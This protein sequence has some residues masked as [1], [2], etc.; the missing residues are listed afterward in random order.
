[1]QEAFTI[2]QRVRWSDV[3]QAGIAYYGHLL[4]FVDVVEAELFR[5]VGLPYPEILSRFDILLPR[6]RINVEFHAPA[7][8]DDIVQVSAYV[9]GMR[10]KLF[11]LHV[12]MLR[13]RDLRLVAKGRVTIACVSRSTR[14][15]A[16]IPNELVQ[17][18]SAYAKK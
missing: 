9:V 17:R 8:L 1:M 10:S 2:E 5:E 13:K 18:L 11:S 3:D 6:V 16:L 7:M 4:T 12:A 15:F 14:K